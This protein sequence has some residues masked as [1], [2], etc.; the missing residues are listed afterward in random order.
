MHDHSS[1]DTAITNTFKTCSNSPGIIIT[2]P[3]DNKCRDNP[4]KLSLNGKYKLNQNRFTKKKKSYPKRPRA[5]HNTSQYLSSIYK[6]L[7]DYTSTTEWFD[8]D[9]ICVTGG[10]MRG[11]FTNSLDL[12][13]CEKD[14]S[15]RR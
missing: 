3:T 7:S 12:S 9:E 14:L 10:T 11:I 15:R 2:N 4:R 1:A 13:G 5:P 8:L 6:E